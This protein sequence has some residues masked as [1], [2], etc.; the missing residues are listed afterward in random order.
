[1]SSNT[2]SLLDH[3]VKSLRADIH[4]ELSN[5]IVKDLVDS[6]L[7][8]IRPIVENKI[9]EILIDIDGYKDFSKLQ[10]QINISVKFED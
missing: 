4:K 3:A 8:N 5:R 1:M 7:S 2:E 9:G 10:E 6:F